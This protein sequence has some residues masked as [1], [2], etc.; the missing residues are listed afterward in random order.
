LP[1]NRYLKHIDRYT[2]HY[3]S[4]FITGGNIKF[5][6]LSFPDTHATSASSRASAASNA[7]SSAYSSATTYNPTAPA[8]EEAI[9]NFFMELY[10]SWVKTIMN[11]FYQVNMPVRSPVFRA[12]V[13]GAAKKYL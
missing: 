8:V 3:I 2:N 9:K 1:F 13:A 10:D 11:P 7:R 12:R 5:I 4:A 6:L